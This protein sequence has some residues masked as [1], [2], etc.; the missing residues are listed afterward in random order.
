MAIT[1]TS[2]SHS[3]NPLDTDSDCFV[4]GEIRFQIICAANKFAADKDLWPG[5]TAGNRAQRTGGDM[6]AKTDFIV[7]DALGFEQCLGTSAVRAPGLG[8][9]HHWF[10]GT[11]AFGLMYLNLPMSKDRGF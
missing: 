4:R 5:V 10:C 11:I 3:H 2:N 9:N 1:A 7:D 6:L 8:K